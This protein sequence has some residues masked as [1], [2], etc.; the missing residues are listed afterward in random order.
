MS[1]LK[2][3]S[4]SFSI[5]TI[6]SLSAVSQDIIVGDYYSDCK[7]LS[8]FKDFTFMISE[9]PSSWAKGKWSIKVDTLTLEY[10]PIY[11][12]LIEFYCYS[13]RVDNK[14]LPL[15]LPQKKVLLS[16]DELPETFIDTVENS[17]EVPEI[18]MKLIPKNQEKNIVP[19]KLLIK[20]S[21]LYYFNEKGQPII[22][23]CHGCLSNRKVK[24]GWRK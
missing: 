1:N 3:K 22:R 23:G 7:Q 13:L 15:L 4:I 12:T 21:V 6:I 2:I 8:L 17:N 18:E 16:N 24:C 9:F 10:I 14:T 5:F 11:D 19:P 20:K